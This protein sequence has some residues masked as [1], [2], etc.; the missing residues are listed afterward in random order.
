MKKTKSRPEE[1]GEFAQQINEKNKESSL[2]FSNWGAALCK[3][4][5]FAE[6]NT[7]KKSLN[8]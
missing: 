8:T 2:K 7:R 4:S 1:S 5:R 3:T 6:Y